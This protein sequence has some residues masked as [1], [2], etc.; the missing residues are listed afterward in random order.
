MAGH[1]GKDMTFGTTW[2]PSSNLS[3]ST[4]KLGDLGQVMQL[5]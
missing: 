2:D 1:R 3:F 4:Y 5:L